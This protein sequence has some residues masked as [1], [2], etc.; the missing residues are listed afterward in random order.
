MAALSPCLRWRPASFNRPG[1]G[2]A[3]SG[4]IRC[5]KS[6]AS[7]RLSLAVVV[8]EFFRRFC[9]RFSPRLFANPLNCVVFF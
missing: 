2:S 7:V 4:S 8:A 5:Q 6:N 3:V 9:F 1:A